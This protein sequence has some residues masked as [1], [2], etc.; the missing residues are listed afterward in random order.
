TS[1][2]SVHGEEVSGR[3]KSI[4]ANSRKIV[5]SGSK[6]GKDVTI[7]FSDQTKISSGALKKVPPTRIKPG[8][9]VQVTDAVLASTINIGREVFG[10]IRSIDGG[11]TLR[12][13]EELTG[14]DITIDL[15]EATQVEGMNGEKDV[16]SSLAPGARVIVIRD[17]ATL[18]SKVVIET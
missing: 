14:K 9:T 8:A 3:V 11:R 13:T 7:I 4:D 10:T 18:A 6:T 1:C 12:L 17:G 15:S 16:L 2:L 5:I